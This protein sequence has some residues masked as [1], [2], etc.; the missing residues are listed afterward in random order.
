MPTAEPG[1]AA[2]APDASAARPA[3]LSPRVPDLRALEL[4]LTVAAV[5]SL[6]EAARV[7]GLTQQAVSSRLRYLERQTGLAVLQRH[8]GGTQLT[9]A[10]AVLA[11]WARQVVDAAAQLDAG[12][13]ALRTERTE[14]LRVGASLTI[15]EYLLP[16]WLVTFQHENPATRVSLRAVNSGQV[17]RDV[18]A[19]EVDLGFVET[20]ATP[21][22]LAS[23]VI[24][25]DQ[26][27]LVVAPGHP[28]ARRRRPISADELV[29]APLV[30]RE[31]GSG[32]RESLEHL[33]AAHGPLRPLLELSS[34]TAIKAAVASGV[35]P[36]VVS[37]LTVRDEV[38]DGRLVVCPVVGAEL[39][40]C[41]APSGCA[42]T[43]FPDRS[44][45][46][47]RWPAAV[48]ASE[49]QRGLRR[50]RRPPHAHEAGVSRAGPPRT[51]P[52]S[53]ARGTARPSSR[54]ASA[55]SALCRCRA[56]AAAPALRRERACPS[57]GQTLSTGIKPH[58]VV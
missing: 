5:G 6:G 44:A 27:E 29:R 35:A 55:T 48:L 32:T 13:H 42:D 2:G 16:G 26:L 28:W 12:V 4:L 18:R 10:G 21:T 41:C 49:R 53:A 47:S 40:G 9:P 14:R 30:A 43:R 37:S 36:A 57:C 23:A 58:G 25:R 56:S 39:T 45:T 19:G 31:P 20:T 51:S 3:P 1:G 8:R 15:A 17:A 50:A 33:L 22:G 11:S 46:C 24:G 52:A 34:T 38:R 54:S 7:H